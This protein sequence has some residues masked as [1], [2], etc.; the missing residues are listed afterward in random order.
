[1]SEP[2]INW[3]EELK[4]WIGSHPYSNPPW[5]LRDT[6]GSL[7]PEQMQRALKGVEEFIADP[8]GFDLTIFP[9]GETEKH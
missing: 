3:R 6:S 9:K 8:G 5:H 7:S 1:M 2:I 4:K